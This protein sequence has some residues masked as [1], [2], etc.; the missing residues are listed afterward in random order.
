VSNPYK[1]YLATIDRI[2]RETGGERAIKTFRAVF[3]DP[4]IRDSFTH[5]PGQTCMVSVFG[6]GESMFAISSSPTKKDYIEFSV[7]RLGRVTLALHEME[8]GA[9]IG[10]RGP[11]GNGFP[12]EEWKGK[13]LIFIG[14]GIGQAPLRS[15][16]QYVLDKR[17][18][19]GE[20]SLI[21]GARTPDDLAFYQEFEDM[22]KRDDID[23]RLSIDVDSDGWYRVNWDDPW[24]T[25]YEPDCRKFTGFVPMIVA[26]IKPR[27][28][29]AIA[30]TCGP[31]IM[32]RF[33]VQN[34]E[35]LG[36]KDSQ[37]Y[38]TLEN[39]MKCGIGKCGRCNI[40]SIYVCKDGPVFTREQIK[41]LPQEF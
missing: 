5:R 10:I 2:T 26:V 13:N 1:P 23:V 14:G 27:P 41:K 37:I 6:K 11:Y 17:E 29:N 9:T 30:L 18:D 8:A 28:D 35:K 36:F 39:K 7:M 33:V 4:A 40:G 16:I 21:Y 31:P 15:V 25:E 3:K 12:V 22:M 32:I 34:L 20:L 19:Y 38:T 24:K